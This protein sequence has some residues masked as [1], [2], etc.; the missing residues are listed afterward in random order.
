L[1]DD[2]TGMFVA[3]FFQWNKIETGSC[4]MQTPEVRLKVAHKPEN[5]R[6]PLAELRASIETNKEQSKC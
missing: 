1:V 2:P 3:S 4:N 5:S 6:P